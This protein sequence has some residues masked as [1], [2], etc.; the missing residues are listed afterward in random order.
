MLRAYTSR[1]KAEFKDFADAKG[2]IV[3]FDGRLPHEV[4]TSG[5]RG[6]RFTVIVYK[7][8]DSRK[9]V[10]DPIFTSPAVVA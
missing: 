2:K 4:I 9:A 5:F 10:D 3:K 7:N 6:D 1:S 8:Y